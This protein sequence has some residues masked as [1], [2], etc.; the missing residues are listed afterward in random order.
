MKN[1]L[2]IFCLF[3]GV[4]SIA[5]Q[6]LPILISTANGDIYEV[7]IDSCTSRFICATNK[8]LY[9][10]AYTPNGNLWGIT[11]DTLYRIDTIT[12]NAIPVKRYIG[13]GSLVSLNDSTLLIEHVQKI[14]KI[15]TANADTTFVGQI[16]F[17]G[18]GDLTWYNDSLYMT[19][20]GFLI[21]TILD[22]TFSSVKNVKTINDSLFHFSFPG[23]V[24]L[25]KNDSS[26]T[27]VGF[28]NQKAYKVNLLDATF[29][30]ICAFTLNTTHVI[31]GATNMV[32]P[33]SRY[34]STSIRNTVGMKK[35]RMFPNPAKL[36]STVYIE[37]DNFKGK[38]N[39][40]IRMI[41]LNGRVLHTAV[42]KPKENRLEIPLNKISNLKPGNVIIEVAAQQHTIYF[43]LAIL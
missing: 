37:A 32:F 41:D 16:G 43:I 13:S 27:I 21:R 30:E 17:I 42:Y 4:E 1:A 28:R 22:S 7:N 40:V 6:G 20:N 24:T 14:Y 35:I 12:G 18:D 2:L 26:K 29:Q 5:Q 19:G 34:P 10:I 36:G 23:L 9:D 38:E 8:P 33:A 31:Y 3:L 11:V 25:N 39:I 15:S